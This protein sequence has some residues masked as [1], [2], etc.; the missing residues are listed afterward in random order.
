MPQ[1]LEVMHNAYIK[2]APGDLWY[3]SPYTDTP[4]I[5]NS[6]HYKAA[7][8]VLNG[9]KLEDT[10]YHLTGHQTHYIGF[11]DLIESIKKDGVK[12]SIEV[13]IEG[14]GK[15]IIVDGMHRASIALALGIKSIQAKVIYRNNNWWRFRWLVADLSIKQNLKDLYQPID[16][17]DF[18]DF[19]IWRNDTETRT[20][21]IYKYITSV[22]EM[23]S[24]IDYACNVGGIAIGL[25][26]H[27]ISMFGVD[28]PQA[29]DVAKAYAKL[30][31]VS[32]M[33]MFQPPEHFL[34]PSDF[35]VVLSF[36]NHHWTD[37][38][39]DEGIRLF[40]RFIKA[41]KFII[42]DAPAPGDPVGG[43]SKYVD[44]KN[45]FEWCDQAAGKPGRHVVIADI[46]DDLKRPL[47]AWHP[48]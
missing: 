1:I 33:T 48:L 19:P 27:G 25:A 24:G 29:V 28:I 15:I 35:M 32:D 14:D 7:I 40:Q 30:K 31:G 3:Q 38:R 44:I 46:G 17:P 41:A 10:E 6:E 16:H 34:P 12:L 39:N 26:K 20:R 2:V 23:R 47:L 37:G 45:V 5:R 36:L 9:H 22:G 21:H 18:Q 42:L 13:A 4:S 43:D 11:N 8:D